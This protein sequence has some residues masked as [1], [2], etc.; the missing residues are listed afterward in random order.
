MRLGAVTVATR[1]ILDPG[2]RPQD[3]TREHGGEIGKRHFGAVIGAGRVINLKPFGRGPQHQHN[4]TRFHLGQRGPVGFFEG[5]WLLNAGSQTKGH[6]T[7]P[8]ILQRHGLCSGGDLKLLEQIS[9]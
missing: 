4:L 3:G 1:Q 6:Q 5:R 2:P 8:Q 7:R 9:G